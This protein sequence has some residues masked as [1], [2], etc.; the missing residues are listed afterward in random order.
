MGRKKINIIREKQPKICYVCGK[1]VKK[2]IRIGSQTISIGLSNQSVD[3]F[4]CNKK[5]CKL[6]VIKGIK[7]IYTSIGIYAYNRTL[8][9][10]ERYR[11]LSEREVT[12]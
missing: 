10:S 5:T 9:K 12:K 1:T 6:K 7:V 3:I 2:Y 8:P 4:R 11:L